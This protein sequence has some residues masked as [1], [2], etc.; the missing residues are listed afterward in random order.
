MAKQVL[1]RGLSSLL[2]AK[3]PDGSGL[4]VESKGPA[5]IE[6]SRGFE[7]LLAG[8]RLD[9]GLSVSDASMSGRQ[10]GE[11]GLH[12]ALAFY[13]FGLDLLLLGVS[14]FIVLTGWGGGMGVLAAGVFTAI[15]AA[16]AS[17]PFVRRGGLADRRGGEWFVIPPEGVIRKETY[18]VHLTSPVFIGRLVPGT[19]PEQS[20]IPLWIENGSGSNPPEK[21]IQELSRI[22]PGTLPSVQKNE[23]G[24]SNVLTRV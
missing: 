14:A 22:A 20:V 13:C 6:L 8:A 9:R 11:N 16:A 24:L 23:R 3:Q 4:G 15:G 19:G 1:G 12:R 7:T 18:I 5:R 10:A 2:G 17:V 21:L